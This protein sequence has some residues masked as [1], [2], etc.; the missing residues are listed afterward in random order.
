[1]NI[2]KHPYHLLL[3]AAVLFMTFGMFQG[4]DTID[5]HMHDTYYVLPEHYFVWLPVCILL[6]FWVVYKAT[7]SR[8]ASTKLSTLHICLT[9]SSCILL[10][11]IPNGLKWI[12]S[13]YSSQ[14]FASMYDRFLTLG[15]K[16]RQLSVVALIFIVCSQM[17]YLIN[18]IQGLRKS[19]IR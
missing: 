2:E 17:I 14:D 10:S 19:N 1:M 12:S 5:L 6:F 18:L 3:I 11:L 13:Q 8:L 9:I 4:N 15:N 16:V 7:A